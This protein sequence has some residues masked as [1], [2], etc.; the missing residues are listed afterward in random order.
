MSDN[1]IVGCVQMTSTTDI[2]ENIKISSDLIREA[3]GQARN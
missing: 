3:H 1:L 2:A